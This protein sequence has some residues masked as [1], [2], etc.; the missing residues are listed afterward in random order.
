MKLLFSKKYIFYGLIAIV[1]IILLQKLIY[2]SE[3]FENDDDDDILYDHKHGNHHRCVHL[4]H[5]DPDEDEVNGSC[6]RTGCPPNYEML[7]N[8]KMCYPKCLSGYKTIKS[9]P[10]R[11]YEDCPKGYKVSSNGLFCIREPITYKKDAV[12]CTEP[13]ETIYY[14]DQNEDEDE[15]DKESFNIIGSTPVNTNPDRYGVRPVPIYLQTRKQCPRGYTL[16]TD[17]MCYENCPVGFTDN[18][19]ECKS[20]S[21]KYN[22]QH[23][24]RGTGISYQ[25]KRTLLY[26]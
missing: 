14:N 15:F 4:D 17:D 25:R 24:V 2:R 23:Y 3:H 21:S 8:P 16:Y 19:R 9:Q 10:S 11:C 5:C 13:D 22:R 26:K 20:K 18:K 1:G 6:I 12:P 7:G